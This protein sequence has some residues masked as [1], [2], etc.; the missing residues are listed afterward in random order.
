[1][2]SI[3]ILVPLYEEFTRVSHSHTVMAEVPAIFIVA[4]RRIIGVQIR[5]HE[6]F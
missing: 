3:L 4:D 5:D 6:K 1:M 2:V